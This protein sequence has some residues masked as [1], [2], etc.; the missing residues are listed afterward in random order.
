[1]CFHARRR[2]AARKAEAVHLA[3][4]RVTGDAAEA[5]CDLAGTQSLTP[6]LFQQLY[7]SSVQDM[8]VAPCRI[9]PGCCPHEGRTPL[10]R[11]VRPERKPACSAKHARTSGRSMELDGYRR[12]D[13]DLRGDD[14]DA[15]DVQTARQGQLHTSPNGAVTVS[16]NKAGTPAVRQYAGPPLLAAAGPSWAADWVR[17]YACRTTETKQTQT[18]VRDWR[19]ISWPDF[20]NVLHR[21]FLRKGRVLPIRGVDREPWRIRH[22]M[23]RPDPENRAMRARTCKSSTG[24]VA[25]YVR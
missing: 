23:I 14:T 7:R 1:M 6:E 2:R 17:P 8:L 20:K 12:C 24:F 9:T 4:H 13:W 5:T 10:K 18:I 21:V 19:D 22:R 25:G 16:P 15:Y 3:D 11:R